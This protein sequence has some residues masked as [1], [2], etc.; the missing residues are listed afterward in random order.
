VDRL[1]GNVRL[2]NL[3]T[4]VS[5]VLGRMGDGPGEYR[6]A[7]TLLPLGG[8]SVG[9]IDAANPRILAITSDG[10]VG[11][12]V[13]PYSK[14]PSTAAILS[15]RTGD[16]RGWFYG[17]TSGTR[18]TARGDL[19][20]TDSAVIMRWKP[21]TEPA[22]I[23]ARIYR[24]PPPGAIIASSGHVITRPGAVTALSPWSTW[25]I[26]AD[27]RA[28]LV[29]G[30]P[31]RVDIISGMGERRQ[32]PVISFDRVPLND[33]I[34][35]AFQ[36]DLARPQL[37]VIVERGS[38][39]ATARRSVPPRFTI[40]KWASEVPPFRPDA[41]VAFAPDGLL[42]IQRTTFRREGGRYDLI[43]PDGS[44]VD[45]VRFPDGHRV[46]GFGRDAMYVV[47]RDADDLEFLQRRPLPKR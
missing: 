18:R 45:R 29:Y 6:G 19:I 30:Q 15:V 33:S 11:G 35:E 8:D 1:E 26:D 37:T 42:W 38:G 34:K 5:G 24:P 41:F 9:V 17:E 16:E 32:G 4:G 39:A 25:V 14:H 23:V 2:A 27:G 44:L 10:A 13:P 22:E 7:T 46:V 3:R 36:S 47:R 31:Y 28:A 43:G 20:L 21:G 40:T 12:F